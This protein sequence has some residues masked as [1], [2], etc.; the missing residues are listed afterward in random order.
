MGFKY[1][2]YD[3]SAEFQDKKV[4]NVFAQNMTVNHIKF[5]YNYFNICCEIQ[6]LCIVQTIFKRTPLFRFFYR[7][8]YT[9][10]NSKESFLSD[11]IEHTL[12]HPGASDKA[13]NN[14]KYMSSLR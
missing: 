6:T 7:I 11:R 10:E 9:G 8:S 4:S 5:H 14:A 3:V 13:L 12:R 1:E 2:G